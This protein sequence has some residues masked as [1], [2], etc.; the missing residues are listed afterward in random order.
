MESLGE[1]FAEENDGHTLL[2]FMLN[3]DYRVVGLI[4]SEVMGIFMN[5]RLYA[6]GVHPLV[7]FLFSL[8]LVT[9][10]GFLWE[11]TFPPFSVP[12]VQRG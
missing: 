7:L 5:V 12:G 9:A 6:P 10:L 3:F 1:G 8:F 2:K 11:N 4:Q